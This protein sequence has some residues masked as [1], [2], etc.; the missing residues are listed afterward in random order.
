MFDF[1][2]FFIFLAQFS[3]AIIVEKD[4]KSVFE[5]ESAKKLFGLSTK[6][7]PIS[8]FIPSELLETDTAN[9][10][11]CVERNGKAYPITMSRIDEYRV[12]TVSKSAQEEDAAFDFLAT[13]N[14]AIRSPLAMLSA[15]SNTMMPIVENSDNEVLTK[16]LATIYKNYFKLLRLSNNIMGFAEMRSH[17]TTLRLKCVDLLSLCFNLL[18]TV[19][20]LIKERGLKIRFETTLVNAYVMADFD[21]L[22]YVLLNLLSN[23][24]NHTSIGDEIIVNV[25]NSGS[26]YAVA[27]TDT[28]AGLTPDIIPTLFEPRLR[29]KTFSDPNHGLGMG[30]AYSR[31]LITAHGGSMVLESREHK[32]TTVKFTIPVAKPNDVLADAPLRYGENGMAPVLTELSDILDLDCFDAKY[33]D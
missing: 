16:N 4:G 18:D 2:N 29:R 25:S 9:A 32:G 19:S 24:L 21:K 17:S 7:I 11:T 23:S 30:L 5:N 3:E 33:L 1:S 15:A 20:L 10:N 26:Y 22:E 28:G 8:D 13:I 14:E 31:H 12:F 6:N 27:V